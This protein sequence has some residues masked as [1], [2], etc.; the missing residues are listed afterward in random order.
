MA[1]RRKKPNKN[2]SPEMKN[3]IEETAD[4]LLQKLPTDDPVGLFETATEE[5]GG[6]ETEF[7]AHLADEK[8]VEVINYLLQLKASFN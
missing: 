4:N 3:K 8:R 6:F 2:L 7:I 5:L 1:K